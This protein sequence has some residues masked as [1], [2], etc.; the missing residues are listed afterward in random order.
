L[1][2]AII[3]IVR[4]LSP[5]RDEVFPVWQGMQYLRD[6]NTGRGKLATLDN[7]RYGARPWTSVRDVL[8]KPA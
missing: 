6:M 3:G 1:L 7:D 4:T 8:A 5:G 2:S